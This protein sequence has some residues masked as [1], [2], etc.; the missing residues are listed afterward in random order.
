MVFCCV[1]ILVLVLSYPIMIHLPSRLWPCPVRSLLFWFCVHLPDPENVLSVL[2]TILSHVCV[3]QYLGPYPYLVWGSL[4]VVYPGVGSLLSFAL[5]SLC[6]SPLESAY[7]WGRGGRYCHALHSFPL[8]LSV[9]LVT[10]LI[11]FQPLHG[12]PQVPLVCSLPKAVLSSAFRS[13]MLLPAYAP[14]FVRSAVFSPDS[15]YPVLTP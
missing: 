8:I 3:C 10:S 12:S 9:T 7:F 13:L 11:L 2:G 14:L 5:L 15:P 1:S 4:S 6:R